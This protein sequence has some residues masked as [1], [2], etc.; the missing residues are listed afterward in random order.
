MGKI[1]STIVD[2]I[3]NTCDG[4]GKYPSYRDCFD[5]YG[6]GYIYSPMCAIYGVK[7]M[8]I[9]ERNVETREIR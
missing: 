4:S 1:L 6:T 8:I 5:C 3:C 2:N 7:S 9:T